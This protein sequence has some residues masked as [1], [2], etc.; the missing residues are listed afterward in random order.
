MRKMKGKEVVE[1][2]KEVEA[3]AK[4]YNKDV[5][6]EYFNPKQM[7]AILAYITALEAEHEAVEVYVL[8][9]CR[10]MYGGDLPC[11]ICAKEAPKR[12]RLCQAHQAVGEVE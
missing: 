11:G 12:W 9:V 4:S 3:D 5:V 10:E 1:W 7:T 2:W 6:L 8:T